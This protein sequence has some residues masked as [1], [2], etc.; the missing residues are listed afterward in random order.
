MIN[1]SAPAFTSATGLSR[2]KGC[3]LSAAE[4]SNR[5]RSEHKNISEFQIVLQNSARPMKDILESFRPSYGAAMSTKYMETAADLVRFGAS[6]KI[7][8]GSC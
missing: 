7:E 6:V 5:Q 8:C 1:E 4:S 2:S 3:F